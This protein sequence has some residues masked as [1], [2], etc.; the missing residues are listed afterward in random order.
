MH[1][2]YALVAVLNWRR[3]K[4]WNHTCLEQALEIGIMFGGS[5]GAVEQAV[6]C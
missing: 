4:Y 2:S 6:V 5:P 3:F 1:V